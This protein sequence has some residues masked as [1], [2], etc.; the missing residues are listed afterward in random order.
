MLFVKLEW[1][2]TC[3]IVNATVDIFVVVDVDVDIDVDV[4]EVPIPAPFTHSSFN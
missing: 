2:D 4:N 1:F 3:S